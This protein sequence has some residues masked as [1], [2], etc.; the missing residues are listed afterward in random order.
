MTLSHTGR[1]R[2]IIERVPARGS[3]T[4]SHTGRRR[5][6]I[7]RV[8]ARG[9]VTLSMPCRTP[10]V[11]MTSVCWRSASSFSLTRPSARR[12]SLTAVCR[13]DRLCTLPSGT[14]A[15]QTT[16]GSRRLRSKSVNQQR[17]EL[18]HWYDSAA[19]YTGII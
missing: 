8:P 13:R 12:S 19:L 2:V 4:L 5:V 11:A 17:A 1:R 14:A 18:V 9:S 16:F 3:V 6:I 7:E 15:V 10:F